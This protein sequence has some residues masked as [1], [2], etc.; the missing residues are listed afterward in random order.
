MC[1][2]SYVCVCGFKLAQAEVKPIVKLNVRRAGKK[3]GRRAVIFLL[4]LK[5]KREELKYDFA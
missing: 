5:K 4:N 2:N 3:V 1:T